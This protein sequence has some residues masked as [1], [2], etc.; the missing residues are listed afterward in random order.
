MWEPHTTHLAHAR[1]QRSGPGAPPTSIYH[2]LRRSFALFLPSRASAHL[3]MLCAV[4]TLVLS[5]SAAVLHGPAR[6]A[7]TASSLAPFTA[8][9]SGVSEGVLAL[10]GGVAAAA[11]ADCR[12]HTTEWYGFYC[13]PAVLEKSKRHMNSAICKEALPLWDTLHRALEEASAAPS[14]EASAAQ[15]EAARKLIINHKRVVADMTNPYALSQG[16]LRRLPVS[17]LADCDAAMREV[18]RLLL[19]G[20]DAAAEPSAD[21]AASWVKAC[22]YLDARLQLSAEEAPG[23]AADMSPEA[24]AALRAALREV[25]SLASSR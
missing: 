1:W 12:D 3:P 19:G 16:Q 15:L 2:R 4:T 11:A 9:P 5:T 6:D 22:K 14:A 20:S 8:K 17:A 24:G 21:A 10:R 18:A 25:A 13:Q 23:R 7:R